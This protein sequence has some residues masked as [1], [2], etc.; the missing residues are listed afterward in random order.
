M[1]TVFIFIIIIFFLI[2]IL[3]HDY[4]THTL[5]TYAEIEFCSKLLLLYVKGVAHF[6]YS[7][8]T[9]LI[10]PNLFIIPMLIYSHM[11]SCG[12]RFLHFRN[13]LIP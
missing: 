13:Q 5:N 11:R 2:Y 4:W 3:S 12:L 9:D 7:F 10:K 1:F 6:H 8:I